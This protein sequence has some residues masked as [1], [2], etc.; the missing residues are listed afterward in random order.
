MPVI[1]VVTPCRLV[2]NSE[3]RFVSGLSITIYQSARR[4]IQ[5]NSNSNNLNYVNSKDHVL[6]VAVTYTQF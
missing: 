3:Q 1:W 5:E 4:K 2:N 6:G